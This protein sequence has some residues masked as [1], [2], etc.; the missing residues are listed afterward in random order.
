MFWPPRSAS[1]L[2]CSGLGLLV[3]RLWPSSRREPLLPFNSP[4]SE[5]W[6]WDRA[7]QP[8]LG[9]P[10][11]LQLQAYPKETHLPASLLCLGCALCLADP[12]FFCQQRTS[13]HAHFQCYHCQKTTS[14]P[15]N[16]LPA[17]PSVTADES[18]PPTS[19]PKNMFW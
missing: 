8:L 9:S 10:R 14:A 18:M 12:S 4:C 13:P 19:F 16:A 17:S 7:G 2:L 11:Q 6:A 5:F 3:K 15:P 1:L